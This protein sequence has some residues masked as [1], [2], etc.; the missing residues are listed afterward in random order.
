MDTLEIIRNDE[1]CNLD[2]TYTFDLSKISSSSTN[3]LPMPNLSSRPLFGSIRTVPSP[4]LTSWTTGSPYPDRFDC[5]S[6]NYTEDTNNAH[7][8]YISGTID[9]FNDTVISVVSLK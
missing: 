8:D 3:N 1:G 6:I 9:T 7:G 5:Y 2:Q 4:R